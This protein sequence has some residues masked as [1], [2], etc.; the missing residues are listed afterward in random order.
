MACSFSRIGSLTG[1]L[2]ALAGGIGTAP[3]LAQK[4]DTIALCKA[5]K[6]ER[7]IE[8]CTTI[9][10]GKGDRKVRATALLARA[11]AYWA[12]KRFAEAEKDYSEVIRL[13]PNVSAAYR[14]RGQIRFALGNQDGA[15]ADFTAA[16]EN[17]VSELREI[18]GIE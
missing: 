9:L 5:E 16:I 13:V 8:A 4:A 3:A 18:L 6:T 17:G 11:Q 7:A 15:M 14:D 12:L 10:K 1:M 2:V